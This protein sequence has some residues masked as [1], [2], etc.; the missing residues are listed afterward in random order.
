MCED[1]VQ[2][3]SISALTDGELEKVVAGADVAGAYL[4]AAVPIVFPEILVIEGVS[5]AGHGGGAGLCF[6]VIACG[7]GLRYAA[8]KGYKKLRGSK[9]DKSNE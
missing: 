3:N 4:K 5:K 2:N 6:A 8:Y 9:R 7:I 1:K